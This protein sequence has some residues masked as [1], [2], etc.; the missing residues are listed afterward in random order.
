MS[1]ALRLEYAGG[2][3]SLEPGEKAHIACDAGTAEALLHRILTESGET[4]AEATAV[5]FCRAEPALLADLTIWENAALPLALRGYSLRRAKPAALELL[6][7][8]EVGHAARALPER[9]TDFERRQAAL[10]RGLV[11]EPN[12]LLLSDITYG[13]NAVESRRL[14]ELLARQKAFVRAA[15]LFLGGSPPNYVSVHYTLAD[16]TLQEVVL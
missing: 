9:L 3:V 4:A 16:G 7:S 13:L 2:L 14:Y 8:L 5:A 15:A 12:L 6:R 1:A 11:G 10:A